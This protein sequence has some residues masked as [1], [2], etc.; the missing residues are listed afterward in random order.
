MRIA[1]LSPAITEILFALGLEKHIVCT[2]KFSDFP[3]AAKDLPH[4]KDHQKLS[5]AELDEFKPEIVFTETL[6]QEKLSK[7]LEDPAWKVIH[8]D[9][10]NM[11]EIYD[12]IRTIG[13]LFEASAKATALIEK[14]RQELND[15][16][17]KANLLPKK[18]KVYIEEWH[19]PPMVSGNWVPELVK[20]AG[21]I[22]LPLK[23]REASREVTLAEIQAFDPD[24]IVLSICGA[25]NFAEKSLITSRPGW[26]ELRAAT[27]NSVKVID[28]SLLNRPG[29][30]LTEGSKRLYG[31][32]F[33]NLHS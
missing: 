17:K 23:D 3:E 32:I 2:D 21:G 8:L 19:N 15:T 25:G 6:V 5:V 7:I 22:P 28:D 29:P 13:L 12:S 18:L 14:M 20:L 27:S 30:R 16:K 31:W 10:R 26:N 4:L 33:E 9:P 11:F 24:L 1:S